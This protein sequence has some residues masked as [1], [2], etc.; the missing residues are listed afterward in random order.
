M[1]P[2]VRQDH[3]GNCPKCGMTLEPVLPTLDDDENP[4]LADFRRRFWWTLPLTLVVTLLAM[5]GHRL[6]WFD[7]ATQSWIELVLSVPIVLWA[8][9]PFFVR[10]VQ[11]VRQRSPNMWTLI[12]LGTGAAFVYSVA[13]TVA[14]GVFPAS[15]QSMGRVAVYFEAAAVIISLTLLGQIL[16]LKARSQ[17]SAAIKSLL[18]L[19]PKTARRIGADGSEEDVPLTHVHVGDLLR[20]RPGEKVPVDGVVTEGASAVDES[21]LTGEP[22]P[23]SKRPGDKLIGATLNTSGALV[24]R[25]ER[26]GAQTV[27]SQIVQMVALAQRSKAPMQRMADQVAGWFVMAVVAIA[28]PPSSPGVSSA[29]S[30]AGSTA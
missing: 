22:L 28:V 3:P 20:V 16:E 30:R 19:A 17:T 7:M 10:G 29:P 1:H 4:E 2:E 8:G 5:V 13:A 12:G 21:M 24:M 14:P 23:V 18:G 9:W 27:L 15:F 26:V 11:S 6:G 25:S